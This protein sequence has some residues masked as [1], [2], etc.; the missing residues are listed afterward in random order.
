MGRVEA[1]CATPHEELLRHFSAV[2]FSLP[3]LVYSPLLPLRISRGT[4]E[5]SWLTFTVLRDATGINAV[6]LIP[7]ARVGTLV[8]VL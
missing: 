5:V 6:P 8:I 1:V 7:S 4:S 3:S 2:A